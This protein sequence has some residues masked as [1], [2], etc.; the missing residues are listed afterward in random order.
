VNVALC[1][2]AIEGGLKQRKKERPEPGQ[3]FILHGQRYEEA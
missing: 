1:F 2:S 3:R